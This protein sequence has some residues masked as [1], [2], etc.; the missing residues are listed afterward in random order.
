MPKCVLKNSLLHSRRLRRAV[1]SFLLVTFPFEQALQAAGPTLPTGGTF[2]SGS[3]TVATSAN[4]VTV[5]QATSRGIIDWSSFSIGAGGRV[6]FQN[7]SGATLNRVTG[8]QMSTIL[9]SLQATGTVYLINPQGVLIGP[10]GQI[11]TGGDFVAS[12]LNLPNSSFLS[13]GSLVF[14]G[15]SKAFVKNLGTISSTGGSIF[16]IANQTSNS[17]SLSA[18]KG[19]VGLAAGSEVL[20]KDSNN[21][22]RIFVKAEG[23]DATNSGKISAAQAELKANGGNVYALAGNNG[24]QI[25][26]TG[27]ATRN[28]SVWLVSDGGTTKVSGSVSA[29]NAD[30]KGGFIE[31]SGSVVDIA[32]T[33]IR[34][35][36]GGS[37]V[38]DPVDL[39]I[40]SDAATTIQS[41][42]NGGTNVTEST[43][44][45]GSSGAG[46][47]A[48][49][50]GDINVASSISWNSSASLTLSAYRNIN[51][52]NGVTIGNGGAG[53]L[54]LQ[55]DN[56]AT[57]IGTVV[58]NGT[59]KVQF[60]GAGNVDL[61]YHPAAYPAATNYSTNVTMGSG[62]FTPYMTV[63]S[64]A[65]LQNIN[66]NLAGNYA[67]NKDIDAGSISN[68]LPIAH[69]V[70]YTDPSQG[71]S[72]LFDGRSHTISNVTINDSTD[73]AVGL[74]A[75]TSSTGRIR[76][77]G[78]TGASVH[79]SVDNSSVGGLVGE[80][81]GTVA[82]SYVTGNVS[83]TGFGNTF[84]GGFVGENDGQIS[85]SYSSA[86]VTA[87]TDSSCSGCI[88]VGGFAGD[89]GFSNPS[90]AITTSLATGSVSKTGSAAATI[91]G[92]IGENDANISSSY[93]D[94]QST[95]QST[96]TGFVNGSTNGVT[97][98]TTAQLQS[99][100][101]PSG[102]SSSIWSASAG[103]YPKLG[104]QLP[105][106][107]SVTGIVYNGTTPLGSVTVVGL[108]NGTSF[109]S[110]TTN[111]SGAFT[112]LAPAG[113]TG[114][115][116][117][118]TGGYKGNTFSNNAS[119]SF[120][121]VDIYA[122]SLRLIN[123][124]T[125]NYTGMLNALSSAL[126]GN[127]G[128]NFLFSMSGGNLTLGAGTDFALLSSV[129]TNIDQ[130]IAGTGTVLVKSSGN[131]TLAPSTTISASGTGTPLTLVSG[132]AFIN[133][134]GANALATSGGG[135][136]L[137]YSQNP[138]N[139][140]LGSLSYGFKQYNATYG[141]TTVA[142]GTGNGLLYTRAPIL[143][144]GLIGSTS[145]TYD[146]TTAAA[147]T[148]A[149]LT[150]S[151]ALSGDTAILSA[152][153]ATY[154][155]KNAGSNKSVTATGVSAT[156]TD[157]TGAA[158]YGYQL[159]S[160]SVSG[161]IGNINPAQLTYTANA[162][163]RAYGASNPAFSGT[164]TGFVGGDT[165]ASATAGTLS[166]T[167]PA[168]SASNVGTDAIN[169]SGLT[170]NNGNY[171]FQQ[172]AGN[173][174]ALTID[175]AVL[176]YAA[177]AAS[178]AYGSANP[179][180]SGT[181]TGFVNGDT[182][183]SATSGTLS[184]VSAA[185]SASNV[186][187]YGINGSGLTANNGN[188]TFQQAAGNATALTID[189]ALLTYTANTANRAYGS[190][191][192]AFSGTVTGF[193]NGDTLAS[194]TAGT[195]AFAS[196]ATA[197]SNVGSYAI[198]GSG[199]AA[200]NGNYT[201]Q[202]AAGNA[203]ALT[204]DP[205][206]LTYTANAISRTYGASNPALTGTVTGFVNGDTLGSATAGT[207]SFSTSAT[208]TSNVGSYAI[209]GTGLTANSGNYTLQQ[210]A[211]NATAL[212]I[213]PAL[214]T[215]TAN[216]AA[217]TYGDA[218]PTFSG[219]VSG[220][221]NGDT[222]ASATTGTL[223]FTSPATVPSNVGSY[224][225]NG[226]GLTANNGNYTFQQAAGNATALSIDPALLT[227]TAN[228]ANRTYGA[229]NPVFS[230]TV[231]GFVNGDTQGS[232]TSGTLAFTSPATTADNV[233][234][235]AING[236]G[237]TANNGNYTFQQA[238]NNATAL[239][240]DPAV[241]TYTA[242]AVSRTYGASN[243]L[244]TGS[245]TG[246]VNG[247]TLSTT[248]SGSAAFTSAAASASHVGTYAVNG[249]GLS[250]TNG[251]YTL[252]QAAGN[253]SAL[254]IT[255]AQLTASVLA[256]NKVYDATIKATGQIGALSG[257]LNGDNVSVDATTAA[258]TFS[259]K[260]VGTG[261]TVS[262]TGAALAGAS[263]SDYVLTLNSGAADITPATIQ[264]TLSAN[265][266]VYD[267]ATGATGQMGSLSGVLANDSVALDTSAAVYRFA[268]KNAGS[269]K[270]VSE[271]G[272][273]LTGAYAANYK[274]VV[275]NAFADITPAT[276]H[277][278]LS[279]ANKIYDGTVAANGSI[280][281]LRGVLASDIVTLNTAGASYAFDTPTAA[282]GKAVTQT[283]AALAGPDAAN[284][285]LIV[286]NG[287]ADI[288]PVT[289]IVNIQNATRVAGAPNPSFTAS[290]SGTPLTGIDISAL[291]ASISFH[292]D[293]TPASIPGDYSITG[294]STYANVDLTIIPG[295]L[296]IAFT[297]TPQTDPSLVTARRTPPPPP[298][299]AASLAPVIA[300]NSLGILQVNYS[301]N[302]SAFG[303]L[304]TQGT[305]LASSSFLNN[306]SSSTDYPG[307]V[308][309][310]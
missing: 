164:V 42:L 2:T 304:N 63:D 72:G 48:A 132:G 70:N 241:L 260:N 34:S 303:A 103:Q 45:S 4:T 7:G 94:S 252:E 61:F 189:R 105:P 102:F 272:A 55:A 195:L 47:T 251:N 146:G 193:V 84:V 274:L 254:T 81:F 301:T 31:T 286:Q 270:L 39:T 50:S 60:T 237:L 243:P 68:F 277:A 157:S 299:S 290:Y 169:G 137:V 228:S 289:A 198:N 58:F 10:H 95:G 308:R 62:A 78:L 266:K 124:T 5:Q 202:Q 145:K 275:P 190:A 244:F 170:A 233:G 114:I 306:T 136:W 16:L 79:S 302:W 109:G 116:T 209:N 51:V 174:T 76:N 24:G 215:Y 224:A 53:G 32:K 196:P 167:S 44:A 41:A 288:N 255:P 75:Q 160:T 99:G 90:A 201:F 296:N 211:S 310:W 219:S 273:V 85:D 204:I 89:N 67:L 56:A 65:D 267:A 218:N 191:N 8:S 12:T 309:P 15:N 163:S 21:D 207:L 206:A 249:S 271:T 226:A 27:T 291:L 297:N 139:D 261:K 37:W 197:A 123:V 232:A 210:A 91:G 74:F 227:Y 181:V 242:D 1:V 87:A 161:N 276:V 154:S 293:A 216:T 236:S 159:S 281:L 248:T 97:A 142:Q 150:S 38:V 279:A 225:V 33:S 230:G 179:A 13:G 29:R 80:S 101:L 305:S 133:N 223:L 35:G 287:F 134:A 171:T 26:A 259:D 129:A 168:T 143:T 247:D 200:N 22:Q 294:T 112:L 285:R 184:F 135:R 268:D 245:V 49:G 156:A 262:A 269:A 40:D 3:G 155:D 111:A 162:A 221:V 263:A 126:G 120:S 130:S 229:A 220:F 300:P 173:A 239:T 110:T 250:I 25:R 213:N 122:N 11:K 119:P 307:G 258:Y 205:A 92:F 121:G 172:A 199:L 240:I 100:S 257:V 246:F 20:L 176:A 52:Q 166:F 9:G 14:S 66:S 131:L 192:P 177:N 238:A 186:G 107:I 117:Y 185:T 278:K 46:T 212:T 144:P 59:G 152:T 141:S 231:T 165:Q 71:F 183:A 280:G 182:Q 194:A 82:R 265:S 138:A 23:S 140:T 30:G 127:S 86:S 17:G 77:V 106:G 36:I 253:A 178:R 19:S 235:Y 234:S 64:A 295:V 256:D 73:N 292:T 217:R 98:Q 54:T 93:F 149:N 148:G 43:S 108:A 175:P 96:G 69:G 187:S 153:G 222:Q 298:L 88:S 147:V 203:S 115:L 214:L 151:G 104:W 208:S 113:T 180:F 57:G 83:T 118:L 125:N 282:K 28:G 18:P 284:Y 128:S 264:A 283:G 158:V 188:Y 6:L